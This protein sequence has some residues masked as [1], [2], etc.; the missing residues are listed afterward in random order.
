MKNLIVRIPGMLRNSTVAL[1]LLFVFH[2][3]PASPQQDK[4][5]E[6]GK[7]QVSKASSSA[8]IPLDPNK[9]TVC[10]L[11]FQQ[12]GAGLQIEEMTVRFS[13]SHSLH[14]ALPVTIKLG[15]TDYSS[16]VGLPGTRRSVR[17]VEIVY[18]LLDP[19]QAA[20]I[21]KAWGNTLPLAG[22]CPR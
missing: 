10:A 20:P 21:V 16:S 12:E 13:N 11:R 1:L 7:G 14:V 8:F 19:E 6:L 15:G 2:G 18:K 5:L 22:F 3:L 17:G 9:G 4:W